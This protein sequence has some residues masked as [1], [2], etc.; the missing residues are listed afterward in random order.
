M[1]VHFVPVYGGSVSKYPTGGNE[2]VRNGLLAIHGD[3]KPCADIVSAHCWL[4][5]GILRNTNP[6]PPKA[7]NKLSSVRY[8]IQI[9]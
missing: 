8:T 2:R 1:I 6:L 9:L 5:S 7:Q 3:V 4:R